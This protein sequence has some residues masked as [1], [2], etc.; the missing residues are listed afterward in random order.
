LLIVTALYASHGDEDHSSG[1]K[2]LW[3]GKSAIQGKEA[4]AAQHAEWEQS[5]DYAISDEEIDLDARTTPMSGA[6]I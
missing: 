3:E 4:T 5:R 1:D 6:S 2:L